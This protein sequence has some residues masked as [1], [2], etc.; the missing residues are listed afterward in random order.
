M[1]SLY[2]V[3]FEV[4]AV[5]QLKELD[6]PQRVLLLNWI[7]DNLDGCENPYATNGAKK[8]ENIASG[9]RYRVG[10][11]RLLAMIHNDLV[12]ITVIMIGHKS[13]VYGA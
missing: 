2:C 11:Y 1:D 9:I 8:L 3:V 13:Q 7:I 4:K 12:Q 10:N 5:K 6:R